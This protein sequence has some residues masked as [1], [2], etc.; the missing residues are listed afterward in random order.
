MGYRD[1]STAKGHIVDSTGHGDFTTIGAALTAAVS[2]QTI[3]IRPGTYTENPTLKAGVDLVAFESDAVTPNVIINGECTFTGAGTVT[4]SGLSLQTNSNY[5]INISGS[6]ASVLYLY[7][8]Y[9]NGTNNSL[10]SYTT[11][12]SSSFV[13]IYECQLNLNTTGIAHIVANSSGQI[14]V[15]YSA[16]NNSGSSTTQSTFAGSGV[17]QFSWCYIASP[18][19]VSGTVNNSFDY[20]RVNCQGLNVIAFTTTSTLAGSGAYFSGFES[21]TASAISIGASCSYF[22]DEARIFSSNTNAITGSGTLL[23]GV[24]VYTSSS[25]NNVTTQ[26]PYK[27]QGGLLSLPGSSLTTN[28][29]LYSAAGGLISGSTAGTTGQVYTSNGSGS[30][31]TFQ[32]AATGAWTLIQSQTATSSATIS[33]TTGITST[34]S[35]YVF[36]FNDIL[37]ATNAAGFQMQ[38]SINT[39]SSYV[40][41]GYSGSV[42]NTSTSTSWTNTGST[43]LVQLNLSGSQANAEPGLGGKIFIYNVPSS[44]GATWEGNCIDSQGSATKNYNLLFGCMGNSSAIN[45]FQ[46]SYSSGAIASGLISLY[47]ISH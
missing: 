3:F 43:T 9:L 16:L 37:P 29:P 25:G 42:M 7:N 47:G 13:G 26:T 31:P 11:S 12:S 33:F 1:Y 18:I 35:T 5:V 21:G 28:G 38:Y 14:N 45:A 34:Y 23:Y 8:C 20:C 27:I 41:T 24:I 17:L 46:F 36:V 39:G 15:N 32:A 6:A 10:I 30:P 2:G 44:N 40:S 22:L 4:M 19:A